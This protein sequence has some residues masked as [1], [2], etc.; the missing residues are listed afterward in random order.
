MRTTFIRIKT[1]ATTAAC[2]VGL[3]ASSA[4]AAPEEIQVYMNEFAEPGKFGLDLHSIYVATTRDYVDQTSL[5]QL[6][7]TPELSYGINSHFETAAY[8]LTN[9]RP[10]ERVQGDGVKIRARW[11][12][13]VPSEDT[14]WYSAV[15][16]EL[17]SLAKRFNSEYSNGEVKGILTWQRH[18]WIAGVN[19]NLDRPLRRQPLSPTTA[20]I[21]AKLAYQVRDGLQFGA[22]HYA[23]LGALHG[24]TPGV[25]CTK[26]TFLVTDFPFA[27]WDIHL[28]VGKVVGDVPDKLIL[29]AIIG[30]PI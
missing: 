15:N 1:A 29:K 28:G 4:I 10:S 26:S 7:V 21:D 6:R 9:H 5:H 22:E 30:V 25:V 11:R 17:G 12:P 23:F 18:Q 20:E 16:V 3:H 2:L 19:L 8:F 24:G 13:I 14:V 27:K